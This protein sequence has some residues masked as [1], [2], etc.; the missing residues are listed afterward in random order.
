MSLGDSRLPD[1]FETPLQYISEHEQRDRAHEQRMDFF[2]ELTERRFVMILTLLEKISSKIKQQPSP[3]SATADTGA[4]FTAEL[5]LHMSHDLIVIG[6][7]AGG[8]V[9]AIRAAQLG[10]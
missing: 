8:Y 5:S 1:H 10:R 6:T 3:E 4:W 2:A 9:C 7:G